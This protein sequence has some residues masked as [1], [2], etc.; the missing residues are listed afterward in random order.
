MD[1]NDQVDS[2]FNYYKQETSILNEHTAHGKHIQK[3]ITE[4]NISKL[5]NDRKHFDHLPAAS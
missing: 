2:L 5:A 1:I 4:Y 3:C